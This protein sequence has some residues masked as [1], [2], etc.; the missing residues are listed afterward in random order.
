MVE[1]VAKWQGP[2]SWPGFETDTGLPPAPTELGGWVYLQTVDYAD[3]L[4]VYA[5]GITNRNVPSRFR[6]HTRKT[7]D[8][9]YNLLDM[10]AM[11]RGERIQ[12][13]HGWEQRTPERL[14]SLAENK[15]QIQEW[16]RTQM[17][18]F[19]IFAAILPDTDRLLRRMESTIMDCLYAQESPLANLPDKGMSLSR[20]WPTEEPVTIRNECRHKRYGIPDQF[21]I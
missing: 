3:G 20:R 10:D 4:A 21:T 6:E 12:L 15:L 14:A 2:F 16:A 5:A 8:G 9:D 18:H 17:G 11:R 13:W 7:L 1:L 19:R